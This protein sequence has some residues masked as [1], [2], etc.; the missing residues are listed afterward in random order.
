MR[1]NVWE[2][3]PVV[4]RGAERRHETCGSTCGSLSEERSDETKRLG[5][6]GEVILEADLLATCGGRATNPAS[7]A[8]MG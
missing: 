6:S 3:V 7:V 2:P 5:G 8:S 1:R 4:E